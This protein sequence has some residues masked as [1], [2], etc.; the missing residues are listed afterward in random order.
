MGV[1]SR[2]VFLRLP[3][4]WVL[5]LSF[6]QYRGPL[7][8]NLVTEGGGEW[9][10]QT[11]ADLQIYPGRL[12]FPETGLEVDFRKAVGWQ[13]PDLPGDLLTTEQRRQRLDSTLLLLAEM[14]KI[15]PLADLLQTMLSPGRQL[16]ERQQT[17]FVQ[18]AA[19]HRACF[20]QQAAMIAASVISFLG[21]GAGLT[22]SGDDLALGLLLALNR[23]GHILAPGLDLKLL[24]QE[25]V[26]EAY[27]L[28]TLLSANLIDCASRGQAD[29][30]LISGLDGLL[31]Q[32]NDPQACAA[33]LAGWGNTSG[34][35][36]LAGMALAILAQ[37]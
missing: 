6:E 36:A 14:Q 16:S 10:W 25:I 8:L 4:G 20:N 1:S 28:T 30:R 22:P 9:Q 7:T 5:F 17:T 37:V 35:D 33:A 26:R 19:V 34:I 2:G 32:E 18:L 24:N 3:G 11:G 29:E 21:M 27:Q 31:T 23:W 13:P 15:S 12:S